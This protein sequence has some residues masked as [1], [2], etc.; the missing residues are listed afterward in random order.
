MSNVCKLKNYGKYFWEKIVLLKGKN[1]RAPID[2]LIKY[3]TKRR[4]Y[5]QDNSSTFVVKE[6]KVSYKEYCLSTNSK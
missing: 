4:N 1:D 2:N 6:T 5:K 3:N